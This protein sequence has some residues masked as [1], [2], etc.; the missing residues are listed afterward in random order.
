MLVRLFLVT[1]FLVGLVAVCAWGQAPRVGDIEMY[2]LRT[3][4]AEK[5]LSAA[6]VKVGDPIPPSKGDLQDRIADLQGVVLSRVEAVCCQ[7]DKVT[8]FIGIEERGAPH[9]AFQTAPTG[10]AALPELLVNT[11]QLF[12]QAVQGAAARGHTSEDLTA[13]HA[14]MDDVQARAYQ[15]RFVEFAGQHLD[16]LRAVLRAS[17]DAEQRAIAATVIG[18][19]PLK[20]DVVNDLQA[21]LQDPD[22]AVRANAARSLNAFA[23]AGV[24]AVADVVSR[25]GELG[26]AERSGG[27]GSGAAD[28]DGSGRAGDD[29]AAEGEGTAGSRGDGA[30]EVRALRGRAVPAA[31]A[32]G[33]D[34]GRGGPAALAEG[35]PGVG[36]P[37]G[38][39]R[40]PVETGFAALAEAGCTIA[41]GFGTHERHETATLRGY[42]GRRDGRGAVPSRQRPESSHD[43]RGLPLLTSPDQSPV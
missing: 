29:C 13:G 20:L 41:P 17:A 12:L 4:T 27:S 2:G 25:T 42:G 31:G 1:R 32:G 18:Y 9:P 6:K 8:L 38:T 3:L 43:A 24:K 21:A 35:R 19:V 34:E 15:E 30:V 26:S 33:G 16:E 11:Y 7:G 10:D 14:L 37:E 5:I 36:N 22:E 40:A 23:V 28:A 39:R